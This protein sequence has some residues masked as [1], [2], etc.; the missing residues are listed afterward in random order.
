MATPGEGAPVQGATPKVRKKVSPARNAVG[1]V[2]LVGF[3]TVAILEYKATRDY[4][5]AVRKLDRAM[6]SANG[7]MPINEVEAM[8]GRKPDGP[9]TMDEGRKRM[10]YTWPGVVRPLLVRLGAVPAN[11]LT[12]YYN[13]DKTPKLL[14]FTTPR[15]GKPG[16]AED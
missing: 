5:A 1:V 7:L 16:A 4:S 12:A 9:P 8:L 2:L 14:T 15:G 10:T 6:G 13:N 11:A 3:T